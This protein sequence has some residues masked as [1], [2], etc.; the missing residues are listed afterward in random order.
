MPRPLLLCFPEAVSW[1]SYY[2]YALDYAWDYVHFISMDYNS[3]SMYLGI[4]PI[5][6][7]ALLSVSTDYFHFR[8]GASLGQDR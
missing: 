7:M 8:R 1:I 3:K 5:L 2:L 4:I 6:C